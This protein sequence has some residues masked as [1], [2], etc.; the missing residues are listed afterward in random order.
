MIAMTFQITPGSLA[1]Y[2]FISC[3]F[4]MQLQVSAQEEN[5]LFTLYLVRHSEKQSDSNDPELTSCGEERSESLSVFFKDVPLEAVYSTSYRRTQGTA[6]PT[7]KAKGLDV[8]EYNPRALETIMASLLVNGQDALVVGHSN[9]TGVLAG[10]LV[11]EDIGSFDETIYNRVYQV[12][13]SKDSR[14]LHV[15]HT[16]FSCGE[17]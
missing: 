17:D 11:G 12:V 14:R 2:A 6:L 5:D 4:G 3:L 1:M 9:T 7:A 8:Q 10:M 13:V 16:A 15:M